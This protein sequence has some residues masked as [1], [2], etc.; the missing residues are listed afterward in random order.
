M[1]LSVIIPFK[2]EYE[3]IG[4]SLECVRSYFDSSGISYELILVDDGSTDAAVVEIIKPLLSD[5]KIQLLQHV[6]NLGKGAA[7]ATGVRASQGRYIF[8]TDADLST[9]I[10]EFGKLYPHR[11]AKIVMGVRTDT[12][13]IGVKQPKFRVFFGKLGNVMIRWV[14]GFSYRDTQCGFKLFE[15][16]LAK[17]VF[18]H[19]TIARWGFDFDV[20][21]QA[22]QKGVTGVEVPVIWNHV[23][24][25]KLVPVVDHIKSLCELIYLRVRM[26]LARRR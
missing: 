11:A 24:K 15:A 18:S 21:Y 23:D 14:L 9:P 3:R 8:F 5:K 2:D 1:E 12:A 20:L 25:S 16:E 13:L 10:T 6:G 26:S 7:I 17:D 4:S 22:Y 19:L